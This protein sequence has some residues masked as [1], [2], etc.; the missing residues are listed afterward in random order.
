MWQTLSRN[1]CLLVGRWKFPSHISLWRVTII[2]V[3][4]ITDEWNIT[5]CVLSLFL[6]YSISIFYCPLS[7]TVN[8]EVLPLWSSKDRYKDLF[9]SLQILLHNKCLTTISAFLFLLITRNIASEILSIIGQK[10]TA[11]WLSDD[12][13][14]GNNRMRAKRET[15]VTTN[16]PTPETR[17]PGGRGCWGLSCDVSGHYLAWVISST[18]ILKDQ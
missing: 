17:V 9:L 7:E 14:I 4:N 8:Q 6:C 3:W 15:W 1:Y 10:K 11:K 5:H 16:S 18:I 12:C 13:H 2:Q